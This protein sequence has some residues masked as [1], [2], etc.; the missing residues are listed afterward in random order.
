VVQRDRVAADDVVQVAVVRHHRGGVAI[1]RFGCDRQA[2]QAERPRRDGQ[3]MGAAGEGVVG[4]LAAVAV[5]QRERSQRQ[6]LVDTGVLVGD[7]AC[8]GQRQGFTADQVAQRQRAGRHPGGAVVGATARQLHRPLRDGQRATAVP[9]IV[10]GLGAGAELRREHVRRGVG[11]AADIR[12][13]GDG[14]AP[15]QS[16]VAVADAIEGDGAKRRVGV[17]V[18]PAGVGVRQPDIV[19]ID[20]VVEGPQD[21]VAVAVA[22]ARLA[23]GIGEIPAGVDEGKGVLHVGSSEAGA[24]TG[25][26]GLP[27][28][29]LVPV[30]CGD[31]AATRDVAHQAAGIGSARVVH[32]ASGVGIADAAIC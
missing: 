26:G 5:T 25:A 11:I 18:G 4:S 31:G 6:G 3:A 16:D 30:T 23:P 20:G 17:T 1:I 13:R 24:T 21:H 9:E 32:A 10:V 2:V 7:A 8:A 28:G 29:L 15:G 27:R 14:A 19:V 22:R 12:R